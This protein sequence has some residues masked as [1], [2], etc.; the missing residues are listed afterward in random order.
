MFYQHVTDDVV[1]PMKNK[2]N[3]LHFSSCDNKFRNLPG[4]CLRNLLTENVYIRIFSKDEI[5]NTAGFIN[6][7]V[8]GI[9][10]KNASNN[11]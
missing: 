1:V 8:N 11:L 10:K 9:F 6:F 7:I 2:L 5:T 4:D 3:L